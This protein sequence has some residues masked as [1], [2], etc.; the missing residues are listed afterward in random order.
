MTISFGLT[1]T[2]NQ[3]NIIFTTGIS[4]RKRSFRDIPSVLTRLNE[5]MKQAYIGNNDKIYAKYSILL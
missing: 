1:N 3:I 5:S 2:R 4:K